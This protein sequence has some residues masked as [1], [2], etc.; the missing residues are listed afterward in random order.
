MIK[1][2]VILIL[3]KF[4]QNHIPCAF[5]VAGATVQKYRKTF[6]LCHLVK[7]HAFSLPLLVVFLLGLHE[8]P[9]HIGCKDF[10]A[11]E[12]NAEEESS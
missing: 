4:L 2:F 11:L 12:R 10:K 9:V 8:V 7:C 1:V 3:L 6:Y 5:V